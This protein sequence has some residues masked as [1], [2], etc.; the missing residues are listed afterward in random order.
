[1]AKELQLRWLWRQLEKQKLDETGNMMTNLVEGS[2]VP[3]LT[4]QLFTERNGKDPD[5][6]PNQAG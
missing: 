3:L 1:M 5:Q 4:Q 2:L 6:T